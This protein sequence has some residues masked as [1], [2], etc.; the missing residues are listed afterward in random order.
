MAVAIAWV[1]PDDDPL[2][3]TAIASPER[4]YWVAGAR[5][6]LIK[7]LTDLKVF[8]LVPRTDIPRGQRPL[9]G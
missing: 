7:S 8:I 4:E 3:A 5:D 6:E 2:W 1:N 9:R